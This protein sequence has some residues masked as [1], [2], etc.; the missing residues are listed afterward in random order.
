[1][2]E[3]FKLT[4]IGVESAV[5]KLVSGLAT[6]LIAS[7]LAGAATA[8]AWEY[9]RNENPMTGEVTDTFAHLENPSAPYGKIIVANRKDGGVDV[10]IRTAAYIE[11]PKTCKILVRADDTVARTFDVT[12]SADWM[13]F[14]DAMAFI[15]YIRNAKRVRIQYRF[16]NNPHNQFKGEVISTFNADAPLVIQPLR[17]GVG[18]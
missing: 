3:P 13:Y 14:R 5:R 12:S 18:Q 8:A 15:E 6:A 9:R 11:C 17:K 2:K 10:G 4:S 1:M 7:T 16:Q